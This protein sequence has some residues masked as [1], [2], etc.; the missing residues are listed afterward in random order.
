[1]DSCYLITNCNTVIT[2][3]N[4]I[5]L[6]PNSCIL[7]IPAEFSDSRGF[8]EIIKDQGK[9]FRAEEDKRLLELS[10]L[11]EGK[12][13]AP[14]VMIN[15]NLLISTDYYECLLQSKDI[16]PDDV[17]GLDDYFPILKDYS[18]KPDYLAAFKDHFD[19]TTMIQY[20]AVAKKYAN[21]KYSQIG[22]L[23]TTLKF[24][25]E[26]DL[27]KTNLY[28]IKGRAFFNTSMKFEDIFYIYNPDSID[29]KLQRL[30]QNLKDAGPNSRI[31][32][33][34]ELFMYDETCSS[35]SDSMPVYIQTAD[36]IPRVTLI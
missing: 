8:N 17:K 29:Y 25:K 35:R 36:N 11:G 18:L 30:S 23:Q 33:L 24:M 9:T 34:L 26:E 32:M 22:N 6:N 10:R 14:F 31:V 16:L 28:R 15:K 3:E 27:D 13:S 20:T 19:L 1:M 2:A 12:T 4:Q 21:M 5:N 7:R